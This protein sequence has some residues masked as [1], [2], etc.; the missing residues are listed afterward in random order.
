MACP[1]SRPPSRLEQVRP[2]AGASESW[3]R[4]YIGLGAN[5]GQPRRALERALDDLRRV[6][7]SRVLAASAIYR[8]PPEGAPGPDYANAHKR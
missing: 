5:L 4:A 6:P 2:V 8:S 3:H 1:G 7:Q